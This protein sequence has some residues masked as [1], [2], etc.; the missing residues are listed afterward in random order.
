M[1]AISFVAVFWVTLLGASGLAPSPACAQT[2]AN[3][4]AASG[5]LPAFCS[6][7]NEARGATVGARLGAATG[8]PKGAEIGAARGAA[9]GA[10]LDALCRQLAAGRE[11]PPAA[12]PRPAAKPAAAAVKPAT[13]RPHVA[14]IRPPPAVAPSGRTAMPSGG[15]PAVANGTSLEK[16]RQAADAGSAAGEQCT[17]SSEVSFASDAPEVALVTGRVCRGPDGRLHDM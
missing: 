14:A 5:S 13:A 2:P 7:N 1:N 11:A 6:V 9:R 15:V 12:S 8:L 10:R 16:P 17:A 4:A 3:G